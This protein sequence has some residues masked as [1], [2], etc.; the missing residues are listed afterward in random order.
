MEARYMVSYFARNNSDYDVEDV[1]NRPLAARLTVTTDSRDKC[2][3]KSTPSVKFTQSTIPT[4][5]IYHY[6]KTND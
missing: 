1:S 5:R 4:V 3:F 2:G 6:A